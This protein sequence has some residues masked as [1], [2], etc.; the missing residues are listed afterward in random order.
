M[1]GIFHSYWLFSDQQIVFP[2]G[3][4]WIKVFCISVICLLTSD[5]MLRTFL[6]IFLLPCFT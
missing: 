4:F 3:K 6:L 5:V 1:K 2:L